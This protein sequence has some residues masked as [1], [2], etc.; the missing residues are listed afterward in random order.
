VRLPDG[1]VGLVLGPGDLADARC[2]KVLV[3]GNVVQPREAVEL[4]GPREARGAEH[5]A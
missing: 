2:P 1:R 4:L 5:G 3:G